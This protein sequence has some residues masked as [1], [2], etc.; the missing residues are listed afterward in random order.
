MN[1]DFNKLTSDFG[2]MESAMGQDAYQAQVNYVNTQTALLT[3]QAEVVRAH[4]SLRRA[5]ATA[6]PMATLLLLLVLL[7]CIVLLWKAVFN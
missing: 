2:A 1:D 4:A 6:V 7:P 3:A 5:L